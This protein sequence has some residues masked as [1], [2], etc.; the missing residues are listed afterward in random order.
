MRDSF[1]LA[2][3][4]LLGFVSRLPR[5]RGSWRMGQRHPIRRKIRRVCLAWSEEPWLHSQTLLPIPE[6][7]FAVRIPPEDCSLTPS[8]VAADCN[9]TR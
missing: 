9:T 1:R 3:L 7:P 5:K 4:Q 8:A 2:R 6:V